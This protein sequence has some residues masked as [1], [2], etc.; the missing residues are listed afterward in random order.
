MDSEIYKSQFIV[1][2]NLLKKEHNIK[3]QMFAGTED[4]WY[5]KLNLIRINKNLKWR[6]RFFVL[7]HESGHALIDTDQKVKK[8]TCF[9]KNRP[10]NVRSKKH[11]VHILN[12]EILA[13]NKGKELASK[14]CFELDSFRYE[15]YMTDCIMSY[16]KTGLQS[17]YGKEINVS[18]IRTTFV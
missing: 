10:E 2:K 17:V 8:R 6:E 15:N 4:A 12:D 9:N 13:W 16:V 7:L 14:L 3:V 5:P 11:Y 18:P 1:L